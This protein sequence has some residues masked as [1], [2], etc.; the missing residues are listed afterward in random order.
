VT[1]AVPTDPVEAARRLGA[2]ALAGHLGEEHTARS[3]LSDPDAQVRA[4]ALGAL[5]RMGR[6]T[7]ADAASG[8]ADHDPGARRYACE[9]GATLP[10]ADFASLLDD[11]DDVVVEAAC[12]AV[13]E[14][15]DRTAVLTLVRIASGHDDALCR[16]SAVAALGAIGDP[17]GL[18]AILAALGDKPQIRRRAAVALAAFDT[19]ESE[20]ALKRCLTDPDWQVRQAAEDQLGLTGEDG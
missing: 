19:P 17:Q 6:A 16:E 9:L 13:G 3:F 14:V 5:V 1:D 4:A 8:L 18:P 10:G 12:Y 11:A 15:R 20:A 7:P 2:A